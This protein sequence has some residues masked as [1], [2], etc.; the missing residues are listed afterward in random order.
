MCPM[1][2]AR[3]L[4]PLSFCVAVLVVLV[5]GA[6]FV[7]VL[8]ANE[9]YGGGALDGGYVRDG[10]YYLDNHGSHTEV[11][12]GIWED[13]QNHELVFGLGTPVAIVCFVYL[14]VGGFFP[15]SVGLRRG[16]VV[17][18]RV[19]NVRSSGVI[20]ARTRCSGNVAALAM[21]FPSALGIE[22]YPA[23]L[24]FRVALEPPVAILKEELRHVT[25]PKRR[26]GGWV[27]ISY[28]SPDIYSPLRLH[29]SRTSDVA[30]ALGY[31]MESAGK[32]VE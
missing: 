6:N 18:A 15:W 24:T 23:G 27:E 21:G 9:K 3:V 4:K 30:M 28:M 1:Q 29:L 11:S 10:H 20:L 7:W 32:Q 22:V 5:W 26:W 19:Q 31:I 13:I 17:A 2:V 8:G 12:R 16:E 25:L 14:L